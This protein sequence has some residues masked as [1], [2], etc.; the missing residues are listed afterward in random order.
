MNI[1]KF[2]L[3]IAICAAIMF[4]V[5]IVIMDFS[6]GFLAD[7]RHVLPSP[8]GAYAT[9]VWVGYLTRVIAVSI[10]AFVGGAVFKVHPKTI[11][12]AAIT[13]IVVD[14]FT[15]LYW[16]I[17]ISLRIPE[18]FSFLTIATSSFFSVVT[19]VT[20]LVLSKWLCSKGIKLRENIRKRQAAPN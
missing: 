3:A 15:S 8:L 20:V 19:L 9:L 1:I 4:V 7:V 13:Y 16:H 12:L 10:V 5:D 6:I 17:L 18:T 11:F 2:L 14:W